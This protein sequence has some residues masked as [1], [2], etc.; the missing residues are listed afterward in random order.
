LIAV[1]FHFANNYL[2]LVLTG[3]LTLLGSILVVSM[4]V[5]TFWQLRNK[6]KEIIVI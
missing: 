3:D 4:T 2:A 6:T 1:F 5:Y